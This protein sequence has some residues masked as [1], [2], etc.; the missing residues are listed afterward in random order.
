[1]TPWHAIRDGLV[2]TWRG[3]V[4]IQ[5]SP[6][7]LLSLI[8]QPAVFLVLFVFMFGEPSPVTGEPTYNTSCRESSPRLPSW[9]PHPLA[10]ASTS[11]S[12]M[13]SLTDS[14]RFPSLDQL[15]C[16]ARY[17]VTCCGPKSPPSPSSS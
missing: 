7:Q 2:L 12:K 1:M 17:S 6:T 14:S 8:V 9:P 3:L 16:W 4:K 5:H 13:G 11:T 15:R 10:S